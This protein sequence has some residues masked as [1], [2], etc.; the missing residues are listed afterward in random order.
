MQLCLTEAQAE[1]MLKKQAA[2]QAEEARRLAAEQARQIQEANR[3][4]EEEARR[5]QALA[6]KLRS[7][8]I[9]PDEGV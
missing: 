5:A 9:N 3:R 8:G 4:A 6:E 7:L 2:Q 1:A